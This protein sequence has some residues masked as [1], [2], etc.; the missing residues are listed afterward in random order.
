M[1]NLQEIKD[2]QKKALKIIKEKI[3]KIDNNEKCSNSNEKR[4][5]LIETFPLVNLIFFEIRKKFPK[6]INN[7]PINL[8]PPSKPVV[9]KELR[10]IL[11]WVGLD[12]FTTS[13]ETFKIIVLAQDS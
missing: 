10:G 6:E 8:S 9:I 5:V 3:D 2:S 1:D 7:L 4:G 11:N 13:N 12:L